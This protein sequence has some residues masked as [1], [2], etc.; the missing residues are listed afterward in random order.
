MDS[1]TVRI[2]F[3]NVVFVLFACNI[4]DQG[5]RI[6][7]DT[8]F[9]VNRNGLKNQIVLKFY[10]VNMVCVGTIDSKTF[11]RND[12]LDSNV[13][14]LLLD[15]LMLNSNNVI[16]VDWSELYLYYGFNGIRNN[17]LKTG[18]DLTYRNKLILT[19]PYWEFDRFRKAFTKEDN[20]GNS[21]CK[22]QEL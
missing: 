1:G 9:L 11:K 13:V 21:K 16:S 17:L 22:M 7:K 4:K 10:F 6:R 5:I 19:S 18:V 3:T 8:G 2:Q 15:T 20:C 14:V 12:N